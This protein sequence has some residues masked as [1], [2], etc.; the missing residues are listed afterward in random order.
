MV[1]AP[2]ELGRSFVLLPPQRPASPTPVVSGCRVTLRHIHR[3]RRI[4]VPSTAGRNSMWARSADDEPQVFDGH[5]AQEVAGDLALF[6]GPEVAGPASAA[7]SVG[8]RVAHA[9]IA[10]VGNG[11]ELAA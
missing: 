10:H 11:E 4:S 6:P 9:A 1:R 3:I 5:V 7:R 2:P 8:E